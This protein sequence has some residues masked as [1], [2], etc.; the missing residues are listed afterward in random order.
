MIYEVIRNIYLCAG[1]LKLACQIHLTVLVVRVIP[2][3]HVYL[4]TAASAPR[5]K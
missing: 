5:Q 1:T 3:G 4:T 2:F